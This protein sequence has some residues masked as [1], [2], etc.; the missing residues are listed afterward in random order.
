MKL[1]VGTTIPDITLHTHRGEDLSLMD[2]VQGNKKTVFL[3]LRYYGCTLCQLDLMEYK[4][5]YH[6]FKDRGF[7]VVIVLQSTPEVIAAGGAN[8]PYIV[9]CDPK[10][11][12]YKMLEIAPAKSKLGLAS[13]GAIRKIKAAKKAGF[14][15]G[16]YE[17]E[18]LQLPAG[19]IIDQQGKVMYSKYAKHLTDLPGVDEILM[20][21]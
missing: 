13:F 16:A 20:M 6:D 1:E 8:L 4:R 15:H 14:V 19:F 17:G 12:L 10:M 7:E 2:V 21:L 3:F 9:V 11:E 5:R 18:E